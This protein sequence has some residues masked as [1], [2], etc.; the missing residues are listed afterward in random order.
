MLVLPIPE[1][2]YEL[3]EN[4]CLTAITFCCKLRGVVVVAIDSPIMLVIGI[5]WTKDC[6]ATATCKMLN[7]IFPF[8]GSY[9]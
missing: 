1:N 8:K 9:V 5:L 3:L 2:L 4:S 7:V 6:G